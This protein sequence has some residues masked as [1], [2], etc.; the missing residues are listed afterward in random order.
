MGRSVS[1]VTLATHSVRRPETARMHGSDPL[2]RTKLRPP[3]IRPG[4]VVRPR[5]QAQFAQGLR[6]P[7]TLITAPAGFGK[8]TLAA[9]CAMASGMPLA[10]LSL[11][12]A[13]NQPGRFLRYL[14]AALQTADSRIGAEAAQLLAGIQQPTAEAVLTGL[15]ND[16][17]RTD[18]ELIL[19]MDDYQ[20]ISSPSIHEQVGFLLEHC[21][22]NLHLVIATRADPPLLLTRLRARAQVVELRAADLRFHQAEAGKFLNDVMGL[23]LDEGA[24]A[25]LEAR[26]EGWITG[27]QMASLALQSHRAQQGREDV[28]E[29]I[30][31]FSGTYRYILDYLLEEVLAGQPA[32]IQ[33][34]LLHTSVLERLN[35]PLCDA[36]LGIGLDPSASA[37]PLATFPES[38]KVLESLERENLFL[39][40][41]DE[42]RN[43]YRYHNLF[44]DLL[45]ARLQQS[46]PDLVPALHLRAAAWMEDHH[47]I[48]EAIQHLFAANAWERAAGLIERHGPLRWEAGDPGIV[49]MAEGLPAD[50]LRSHPKIG[51]L[52]AWRYLVEGQ[53][54]KALPQFEWL[55][56]PFEPAE[57]QDGE[58]WIQTIAHFALAF[59]AP[60]GS[61]PEWS[62]LPDEA[63]LD[64]I[65]ADEIVFRDAA[66]MLYGMALGRRA[67]YD[68]AVR[69]S[70]RCLRRERNP[71]AATVIPTMAAFLARIYLVQGRLQAA[72]AL[73]REYLD[74]AN[75]KSRRFIYSAGSL[76][77]TLG[78]VCYEWNSL[79]EAERWIQDGIKANEPWVDIL[80]ECFGLSALARVLQA[81]EAF[82]EAM[83]AAEKLE[84]RLQSPLRPREFEEDRHTL[85]VRI[86]LDSGDLAS[87]VQWAD[88][89]MLSEAY[90]LHP[91][92]YR[93]TLARIRLA[94]GAYAAVEQL[95]RGVSPWVDASNLLRRKLEIH[96]LLAAASAAQGRLSEALEWVEASLTLAE[97]EG[98]VG[99]FVELG[100]PA[101][102]VLAAYLRTDPPAHSRFARQVLAAFSVPCGQHYPAA[103]TVG[104]PEPLSERELEVLQ[105]MALGKTN[106]EI[107]SQL[108]IAAGTVKAHAASIYRKLDAANRTE[109]VS[110]ARQL[111]LLP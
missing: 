4:L 107:A 87:A 38:Q 52:Q 92:V 97:P 20:R 101:R 74:P 30:A 105:L 45:K 19:V 75:E 78:E 88:Q 33:R 108:V 44:A 80:T 55:A 28:S 39:V 95:L 15:V 25:A 81:R 89:I 46:Q 103:A 32:E 90:N 73:C 54:E 31:G 67:E 1:N 47:L 34:F 18:A 93:L 57:L 77:I 58:R 8:T 36:V 98:Y 68:A 50:L 7:L 70:L 82:A 104:L 96:L 79:E 21:P 43:W 91:E 100:E 65:P 5:L 69:I 84:A 22:H 59:L 11:D 76:S 61:P 29:F 24:V 9:T 109:A 6:G 16:I 41:L 83:Q 66:D 49:Q 37:L 14:A 72:A 71:Q 51:S 2:L 99:V 86:Q 26:T 48:A 10:W 35:A 62:A 102:D 12:R 53:V 111:G 13:D 40:S 3:F 42:E 23:G 56:H 110:R 27:L 106:R 94:Q 17:D 64:A 85:K 63:L 60:P